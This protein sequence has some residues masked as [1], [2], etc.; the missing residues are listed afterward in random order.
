MGL[1]AGCL[2]GCSTASLQSGSSLE[3]GQPASREFLRCH[4]HYTSRNKSSCNRRRRLLAARKPTCSFGELL[5]VRSLLLL[6]AARFV[7]AARAEWRRQMRAIMPSL[8]SRAARQTDGCCRRLRRRCSCAAC[9]GAASIHPP[10]VRASV[11]P[12][13][14]LNETGS[15]H[16]RGRT[17]RV[18]VTFQ[19]ASISISGG[20]C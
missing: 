13:G 3:L 7:C 4:Y 14:R 2:L 8:S 9:Y 6:M 20:C 10:S 19:P 16:S 15:S 1:V 5:L 12:A 11:R 17:A 18:S